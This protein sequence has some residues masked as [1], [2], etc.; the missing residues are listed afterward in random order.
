M[1]LTFTKSNFPP[2]I[3]SGVKVHTIRAD[4]SNRWYVGAKIHFWFGNPRNIK[5]K[6][7]PYQFGEGIVSRLEK[8][9]INPHLNYIV[10][11]GVEFRAK[12]ELDAIAIN[13]GFENWEEMKTFFSDVFVGKLIFW[14]NCRWF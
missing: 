12:G 14:K 6:N 4:N 7:K 1:L 3:K 2:L 10:I 9:K 13:D 5:S 8:I 11:D